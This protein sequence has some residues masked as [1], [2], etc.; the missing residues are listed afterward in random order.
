MEEFWIARRRESWSPEQR[1]GL[2]R[3]WA[4]SAS[5]ALLTFLAQ[6][7]HAEH[8]ALL[9]QL[10]ELTVHEGHVSG[11]ASARLFDDWF[12]AEPMMKEAA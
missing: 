2:T 8:D 11:A 12:I 9:K 3:I 1:V 10:A 5:E 6:K 4:E 7:A